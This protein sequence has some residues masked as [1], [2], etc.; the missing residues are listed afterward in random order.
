MGLAHCTRVFL[1]SKGITEVDDL[2][3]FITRESWSKVLENCKRPPRIPDPAG[4][5][6]MVE[7]QAY[8]I[9]A[10]SLRWLKVATKCVAY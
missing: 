7:D 8:C 9:G 6:D 2:E 5:G 10:K 4:G 1:Q 3:E